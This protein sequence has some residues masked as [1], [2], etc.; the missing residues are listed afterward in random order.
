[1]FETNLKAEREKRLF[2]GCTQQLMNFI[3][4]VRDISE[5][6]HYIFFFV[7]SSVYFDLGATLVKLRV[8]SLASVG[9][10]FHDALYL[11]SHG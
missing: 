10:T 11:L 6:K 4:Q 8:A 5:V 1:M 7:H 9:D 3:I 2:H